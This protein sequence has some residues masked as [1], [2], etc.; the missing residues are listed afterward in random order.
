MNEKTIGPSDFQAEVNR[1]K[2]A[3]KLPELHE[4]LGAVA[5]ARK[6]FSGKILEARKQPASE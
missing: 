6:E 4:L 3:G 2:A 5:D 1:L